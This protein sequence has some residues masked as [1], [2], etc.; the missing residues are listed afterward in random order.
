MEMR[1][2]SDRARYYRQHP[3]KGL[4]DAR[5]FCLR[6]GRFCLAPHRLVNLVHSK[7]A[8][9]AEVL[10]ISPRHAASFPT[11]R[12][13]LDCSWCLR[14]RPESSEMQHERLPDLT[15]AT[16]KDIVGRFPALEAVS[17]TGQGEPLLNRELLQMME[18]ARAKRLTMHLTTNALSLDREKIEAMMRL[19]VFRFN[20]S[21]KGR[22]AADYA[23]TTGA[24]AASFERTIANVRQ[25]VA[26]KR[27]LRSR[28]LVQLSYVV[29]TQRL[30]HIEEVVALADELGVD[31]VLFNNLIPFD[32]FESGDGS[33]YADDPDV[34]AV[35]ARLEQR[36]SRVL[37]DLPVLLRRQG[38]T[39]Y[40]PG[41]YE[42]LH[43]DAVGNVTGCM[44]DL[45]PSR[46]YGNVFLDADVMNTS[47]FRETRRRFIENDLP[48]RCRVCVEMSRS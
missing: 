20:I 12:C 4:A 45:S 48:T 29:G 31:R 2:L 25:C 24:T 42:I 17:F 13:D 39:R 6:L 36:P 11:D 22:D 33:L 5:G 43:F 38:F 27:A 9:P 15:L 19:G 18:H 7:L 26:S 40:C 10:S 1:S 21:L 35:M 47:H 14:N 46:S 37:V 32:D 44:R 34:L 8:R 30:G 28:T 23:H 16:F 41:Y 3:L